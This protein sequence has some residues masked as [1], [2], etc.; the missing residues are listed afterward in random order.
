MV[1]GAWRQRKFKGKL[2]EHNSFLDF[3]TTPPLAG[4]GW[5]PEKVEALIKDDS[6]VLAMWRA[7]TTGKPGR[8]QKNSDIVT[9][10]SERGNTRAYTLDRLK[11]ERP[12]LFKL[13]TADKMS[14]NAAA[15]KAGFRK[16]LM[17]LDRV[18]KL[19]PKLSPL[20]RHQIRQ[21]LDEMD[22]PKKPT[23]SSQQGARLL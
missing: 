14:A 16:N 5:P 19:L 3:I 1:S 11:R 12:D 4:C 7:A 20:D 15:I 22:R 2:Y 13:V 23:S 21:R 10:K 8:P 6:E 17:P 18:L 9:I